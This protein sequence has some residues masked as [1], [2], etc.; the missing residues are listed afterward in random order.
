MSSCPIPSK[1]RVVYVHSIVH[2]IKLDVVSPVKRVEEC[3]VVVV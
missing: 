3:E 1:T 2:T